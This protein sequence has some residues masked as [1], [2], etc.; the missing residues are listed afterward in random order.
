MKDV[1][2]SPTNILTTITC[3]SYT[4]A[5]M[6]TWGVLDVSP[7][8]VTSIDMSYLEDR[9]AEDTILDGFMI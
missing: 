3:L 2:H 5:W 4:I 7:N 6:A 8:L 9:L 1:K